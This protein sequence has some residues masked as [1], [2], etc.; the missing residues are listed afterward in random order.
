MFTPTT[1]FARAASWNFTSLAAMFISPE[2]VCCRHSG[3]EP[4]SSGFYST[5]FPLVRE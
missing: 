3:L 1:I 4:E 2:N 5:G